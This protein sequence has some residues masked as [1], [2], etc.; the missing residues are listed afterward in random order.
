MTHFNVKNEVEIKMML[1]PDFKKFCWNCNIGGIS[2][3]DSLKSAC[4]DRGHYQACSSGN[5]D[6]FVTMRKNE[7]SL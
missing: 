1:Q 3:P 6:C 2:D 5:S 7:G 4:L